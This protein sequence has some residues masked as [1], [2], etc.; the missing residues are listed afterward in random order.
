[1]VKEAG[2]QRFIRK[3]IFQPTQKIGIYFHDVMQKS[4]CGLIRN[5]IAWLISEII[6]YQGEQNDRYHQKTF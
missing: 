2:Q 1:M 5:I 6:I 4:W 3:L